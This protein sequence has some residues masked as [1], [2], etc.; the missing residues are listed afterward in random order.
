[1]QQLWK[2]I[3][4]FL[5]KLNIEFPYVPAIPL[6]GIYPKELRTDVQTKICTQMFIAVLF[7]I[8]KMWKQAICPSLMNG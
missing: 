2:M 5:K 8:A 6:F 7:T 3:W 4:L 1:M